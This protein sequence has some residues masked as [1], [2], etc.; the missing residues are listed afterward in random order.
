MPI[1]QL[2][3]WFSFYAPS[4]RYGEF[5]RFF[6]YFMLHS[7]FQHLFVNVTHLM[8]ALDIEGVPGVELSPGVPLRCNSHGAASG[9]CY[10]D[11][12]IGTKHTVALVAAV[13]AYGSFLGSS[14]Q[15][16]AL[17]QGASS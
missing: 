10:P 5:W 17:L 1:L 6:T 3:R 16:G 7:D 15:Y 12:G 8:D 2:N 11:V 9:L 13:L 4:L 14:R